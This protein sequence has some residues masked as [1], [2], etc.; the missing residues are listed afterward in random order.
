M[1]RSESWHQASSHPHCIR[2]TQAVDNDQ[3]ADKHERGMMKEN[4][5]QWNMAKTLELLGGDEMLLRDVI[6]IFLEE[7]PKH[8]AVLRLA[9]AQGTAETA[10]TSLHSLRGELGYLGV[11]EISRKAHELEELGR[12]NNIRVA[13]GLFVQFEADLSALINSIRI[14]RAM[15]LEP[16]A[17]RV[18]SR[19]GQ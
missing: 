17:T 16:H 15:A 6:D 9:F 4:E 11:P 10:E 19:V 12:S 18:S 13:A 14:A 2:G 1:D 5:V 3:S 8:L 7:A